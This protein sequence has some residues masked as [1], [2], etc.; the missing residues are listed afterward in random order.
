MQRLELL[1]L[2][3]DHQKF[4]QNP[5]DIISRY[6]PVFP[7][8]DGSEINV[9]CGPLHAGK[10]SFLR[11][12]ADLVQCM[13]IYIN[14]EDSRFKEMEPES[15]QEIEEIAAEFYR[16]GSGDEEGFENEDKSYEERPAGPTC[17]FLDEIQ[18]FSGWEDWIDRL[19]CGGAKVFITSSSSS[20]MTQDI[21]SR[22]SNRIRTLRLLPF[23]FK[24]YLIL[25]GLMVPRPNFLT[26]SRCDEMLCLFLRYFETGGFPEVISNGDFRLSR[27]FFEEILRKEIIARHNIQDPD[28]LKNLAVFLISNMA[29]EYCMDTLKKK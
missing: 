21:S 28:G 17:Y 7:C 24:E 25:N 13:K 8:L 20:L 26:P 4:F 6:I 11:Q 16:K 14:F 10:T 15:L 29:S 22:F 9:I 5:S 23:S 3:L 12:V 18:N 1:P 27:Q 19:Q 2:V